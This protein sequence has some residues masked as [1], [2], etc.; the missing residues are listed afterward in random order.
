[1]RNQMTRMGPSLCMDCKGTLD[2]PFT[3]VERVRK[4]LEEQGPL[5]VHKIVGAWPNPVRA[6]SVVRVRFMVKLC[7]WFTANEEDEWSA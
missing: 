2:R 7:D 6:P 3:D 1:M 5:N 4:I